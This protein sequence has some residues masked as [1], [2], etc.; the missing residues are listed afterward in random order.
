MQPS[1][2]I[3]CLDSWG[4]DSHTRQAEACVKSELQALGK[5]REGGTWHS[6]LGRQ[7]WGN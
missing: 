2:L 7:N 3:V 6:L 1:S 4:S 5:E